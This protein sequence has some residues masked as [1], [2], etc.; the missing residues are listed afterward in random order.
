MSKFFSFLKM[1]F[2]DPMNDLPDFDGF[3][4]FYIGLFAFFSTLFF[5]ICELG[6][7]F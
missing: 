5:C 4:L 3:I 2:L 1:V 7:L 6:G